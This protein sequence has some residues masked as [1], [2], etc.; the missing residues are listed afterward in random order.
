ME[1]RHIAMRLR[2]DLLADL[3]RYVT[4]RKVDDDRISRTEV[5]EL[6]I[7]SFLR[8]HAREDVGN[9]RQVG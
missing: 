4:K 5:V 3:D 2:T 8:R 9:C 1:R 7:R 6:A